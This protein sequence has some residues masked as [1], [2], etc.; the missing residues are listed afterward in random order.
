MVSAL[1][2]TDCAGMSCFFCI[3]AHIM[4]DANTQTTDGALSLCMGKGEKLRHRRLID[5]LFAGGRSKYAYPLRAIYTVSSVGEVASCFRSRTGKAEAAALAAM[6]IDNLQFLVSVPKRKQHRAVD[7][8][9]LRR[10][11]REAWRLSRGPL[12]ARLRDSGL[13]M[14]VAF[15]YVGSQKLEY[16][17]LHSRILKI[18]EHLLKVVDEAAAQQTQT[19]EL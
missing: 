9:W 10:R 7:R 5:R 16:A 19:S 12:R 6:R 2:K 8:V 14:S 13:A 1:K 11:I 3:F 15:V 4:A 18:M 17:A